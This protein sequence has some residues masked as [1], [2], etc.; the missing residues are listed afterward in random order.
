MMPPFKTPG[1]ASWCGSAFH[2]ATT[3]SPFGKLRTCNPL[4]LAGPQPKQAFWGAYFSC[5]HSFSV[6]IDPKL[7]KKLNSD[8]PN[9]ELMTVKVSSAEKRIF[10]ISLA[11]LLIGKWNSLGGL[12]YS[13]DDYR[14]L[15]VGR[16]WGLN[17]EHF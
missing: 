2:S 9:G 11:L 6:F 7:S 17:A 16:G 3:I 5:K 12:F 14:E 1:K 13:I 4:A 8:N 15:N 10:W